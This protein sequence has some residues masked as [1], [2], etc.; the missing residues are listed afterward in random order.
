MSSVSQ[1]TGDSQSTSTPQ[2]IQTPQSNFLLALSGQ[3]SNYANQTF[4]Q[5]DKNFQPQMD[6]LV[7]RSKQELSP[8]YQAQKG[9]QAIAGAAQLATSNRNT[10][11]ANLTSFGVGDPSNIGRRYS[12]DAG[13]LNAA[14]ATEAGAA[15]EAMK[16][17]RDEGRTDQGAAMNYMQQN[18][19]RALGLD[20]AAMS[21][22]LPPVANTTQSTTHNQSTSSG[23]P[24][25]T[26][27]NSHW[28]S[29]NVGRTNS[30]GGNNGSG[31]GPYTDT[32]GYNS[33]NGSGGYNSD[34]V[35]NYQQPWAA[36]QQ[37]NP[38][39]NP[40]ETLVQG[41]PGGTSYGQIDN[42]NG[43]VY[44]VGSNNL[45]GPNDVAITDNTN[46]GGDLG[47]YQY[48]QNSYASGSGGQDASWGEYA[49]GGAIPSY[50]RPPRYAVGGG[51]DL[52]D[53][54]IAPPE[55]SPSGGNATDD[56]DAKVTAHEFV[57]PQDVALFKGQEFFY[58]LM[59]K[60]RQ[61]RLEYQSGKK[62]GKG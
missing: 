14:G 62:Q 34:A 24:Q 52:Q 6:S 26:T 61:T 38:S 48:D 8:A 50:I 54:G 28:P 42:N 18:A 55:A 45:T 5:Y 13:N 20:Q 58:K 29:D 21:L 11:L 37:L 33:G 4:A 25:L 41:N 35:G 1:S 56:I 30:G 2:V 10:A 22:K 57:V 3:L 12:I 31:S 17:A 19:N 16:G 47:G 27:G 9:A 49:Q 15:N 53:G 23:S 51:V 46:Y 39:D 43:D 59:D 40:G 36:I 32:G 44:Q 7:A 60:S